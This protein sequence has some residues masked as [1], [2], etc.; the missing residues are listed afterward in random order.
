MSLM[1]HCPNSKSELANLYRR[2]FSECVELFIVTAFLTEWDSS[3]RLNSD[4]RRFRVIAGKDFGITR[5]VA[6]VALM[7][8]LPSKRKSDFLV[9]DEVSGFHPKAMFWKGTN[10]RHFAIIGSS[11]LTRAAFETNYEA[12]IHCELNATEYQQAKTW[13][14]LIEKQSVVVSED[15]LAKYHEMPFSGGR[16]SRSRNKVGRPLGPIVAFKLPTP[17]GMHK[18]IA[19][20]RQQ[21]RAFEK[22]KKALIGLFRRCAAGKISSRQFYAELPS[23]WSREVNDRLTGKGFE[24]SGA[25]SNFQELSRSLV[26]I[27][28]SDDEER[29][30][31]VR[32][33][34]DRLH[35]EEIPTRGAFLSE[36]LC[37][38]F[39]SEYPVLNKPVKKYSSEMKFKPPRNASE[40]VRFVALAKKL[41]ASLLQNPDHPAKNLAE[42]DAVIWLEYGEA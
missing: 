28:D 40:G 27:I 5:K 31:V 18:L 17:R 32:E 9:A 19:Q 35:E 24:I 23:Y 41:R 10:G 38:V 15:W 12:N 33:E 25:N 36:M 30:D 39:P 1:L 37:L 34:V 42:L 7:N 14:S 13:I 21:L 11:N 3:L 16:G 26:R 2:A 6:C 4:C 29:D 20:R 8:W 22:Q